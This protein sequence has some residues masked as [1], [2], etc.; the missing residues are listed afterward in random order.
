M[1]NNDSGSSLSD[2]GDL[3][4]L[5]DT[6][7]DLRSAI[8]SKVI[9]PKHDVLTIAQ[10][11]ELLH[12]SRKTL[13]KWRDENTIT[14]RKIGREIYFTRKDILDMLKRHRVDAIPDR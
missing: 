9:K 4:V 13:Q 5:R 3:A 11:C 12:V 1:A 10:A 6:I 14:Y 2:R 8:V 7:E